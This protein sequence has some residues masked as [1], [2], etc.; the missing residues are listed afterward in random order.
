MF[1]SYKKWMIRAGL[2]LLVSSFMCPL[3]SMAAP[4]E[5]V[6]VGITSKADP[7]PAAV[8]KR[9]AASISSIGHRVLKGKEENL[10][11]LNESQYDKVLADIINRVVV[12]YVVEDIHVDYGVKTSLSVTLA[13]VGQMIREVETEIDYGNLSPEAAAYVKQDTAQVPILM[14]NLL[15]GLP[16]D[17]VGWAESVS[18]SAGRDLLAQILPEFQANFEVHSG[19][20]TKVRI[21]LIPQGNIVRTGKLAF[22]KTTI[23]RLLLLRAANETEHAVRSLEGL[24]VAFVARHDRELAESLNEIL[25]KDSFVTTYGIETKTTLLPGETTVL[26]VDALTDHW[27][28]RTEAWV[29]AGRDGNRNT[30]IEGMLGHFVGKKDVV[31][32]EARLY[33]GPMDWNVFAGWYHHFGQ[34]MDVGYKY[35]FIEKSNHVFS[36]IPFGERFA[37]R[38]D[39]DFKKQENEYGLSYKIHN[40]MTLEYVYNDEDGR[41]LRLIANL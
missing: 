6:E 17:S 23:P 38:Y 18:E 25:K 27:I 10:F 2:A 26:K 7:I 9:I 21:F 39:R 37:F 36:Q 11:R 5:T 24:P 12:G 4:I 32:G 35:D 34:T 14:S 33:T 13:P 1:P 3:S 30:A 41:W 22:H 15:T 28:I 29:D 31:F 20:K 8:E 40:Y 16:V 19:E